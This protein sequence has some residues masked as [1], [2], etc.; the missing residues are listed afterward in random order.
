MMVDRFKLDRAL[1]R[2]QRAL[3]VAK[4]FAGEQQRGELSKLVVREMEEGEK[5]ARQLH[6][7]ALGFDTEIG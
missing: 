2:V 4:D 6:Y 3:A 1:E 7:Y 5:A